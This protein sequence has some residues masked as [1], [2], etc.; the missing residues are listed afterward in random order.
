M[1]GIA[2]SDAVTPTPEA[3]Y[4]VALI[5]S[6]LL[7]FFVLSAG[8]IG[9]QFAAEIIYPAPESTRQGLLLLPGQFTSLVFVAIMSVR[10]KAFLP[11][12]LKFFVVIGAV[13]LILSLFLKESKPLTELK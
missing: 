10:A 4:T 5:S 3:A 9:F 8:P 6:F 7:R 12:F 1:A 13:A 11:F 2:F